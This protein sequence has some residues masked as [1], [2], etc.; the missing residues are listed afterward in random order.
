MTR[1]VL[2]PAPTQPSDLQIPQRVGPITV[3]T[4]RY[5]GDRDAADRAYCFRF[6]VSLA[7]E[8]FTIPGGAF[9]YP[10]PIVQGKP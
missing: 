2:P 7:P 3:T 5:L 8:P 10:L 9:A 1:M 4:W 6:N